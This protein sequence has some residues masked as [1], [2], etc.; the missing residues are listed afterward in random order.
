MQSKVFY[1]LKPDVEGMDEAIVGVEGMG[2]LLDGGEEVG[3]RDGCT[4]SWNLDGGVAVNGRGG[5]KK[6]A[7]WHTER[8]RWREVQLERYF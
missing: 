5:K 8:G 4:G 1:T 2:G 3:V 7:W 6:D